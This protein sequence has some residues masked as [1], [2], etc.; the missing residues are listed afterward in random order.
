VCVRRARRAARAGT[1]RAAREPTAALE[2]EDAFS[3]GSQVMR[4]CAPARAAADD[5]D[6]VVVVHR[7]LAF[8]LWHGFRTGCIEF[9]CPD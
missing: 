2:D 4:Q 9:D 7:F 5:D 8:D 6:I 1:L 3:G